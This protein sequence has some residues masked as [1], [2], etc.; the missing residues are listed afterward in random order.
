MK[1]TN[2]GV[3]LTYD[4]YL[5]FPEDGMR[6]ELIVGEHYVTAAPNW[7]HQTISA[8]LFGLIWS[9]LQDHSIDPRSNAGFEPGAELTLERGDVMTTPLLPNLILALSRIFED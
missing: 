7:K 9:Y 6:H 3:K 1:P 2:P 8:N 4:D 5:L